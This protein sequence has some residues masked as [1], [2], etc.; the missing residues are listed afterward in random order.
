VL[1]QTEQ[2]QPL[3]ECFDHADSGCKIVQACR[4]KHVLHQAEQ[5]FYQVLDQFS[6]A[7]LL[8]NRQALTQLIPLSRPAD[9]PA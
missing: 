8:A 6:L 2:G 5:A 9:L 7:D 3:V 4:L 1:R